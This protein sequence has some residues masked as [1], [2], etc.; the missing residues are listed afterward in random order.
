MF[1]YIHM[2]IYIYINIYIYIYKYKYIC[3]CTYTYINVFIYIFIYI[4]IYIHTY[5]H[6]NI[7]TYI[8]IYIYIYM[9]I[10]IYIYIYIYTLYIYIYIYIYPID[11]NKNMLIGNYACDYVTLL[12][13]PLDFPN[14]FYSH[15]TS[16]VLQRSL[17]Q[18][19]HASLNFRVRFWQEKYAS[20]KS[21]I[22]FMDVGT[23]E[24]A[25]CSE[26]FCILLQGFQVFVVHSI[27][28]SLLP[29]KL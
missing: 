6:T 8:Y 24:R 20:K 14:L 12:S 1:M 7:H 21:K 25:R 23:C 9:Y 22:F 19:L 3:I 26:T 29:N 13:G 15:K 27:T 2:Y 5:I 10:Y 28:S 4:Y 17:L 16:E 18:T 11:N